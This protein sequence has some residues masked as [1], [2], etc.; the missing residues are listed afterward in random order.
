[1]K[2]VYLDNN[3]TTPLDERVLNA[4]LPFMKE[5]FGN[6]SSL[7]SFG[8]EAKAG[9][10]TAREKVAAL[11]G[12]E[13]SEI[14]FTSGGT[15]SD[16]I[17]LK[18]VAYQHQNKRHHL[19]ASAIEHHAV[20]ESVKFLAKNGFKADYLN[21]DREGLISAAE[22]KSKLTDDTSVVS[23]M[24]ANNEIGTIQNI[25]QLSEITHEK[26]ALFHTDAVQSA[27]KIE[28]DIKKLK[29]DLL[30]MSGHKIYGPKGVGVLYIAKGQRIVPLFHGGHHEKG[31]RAGT[32]NVAGIVG[33][34]AALELAEKMRPEEHTRLSNLA[35]FFIGQIQSKI[36]NVHFNG[37]RDNDKRIPSTVNL[38]F[39][40]VE[41]ESIILSLDMNGIGVASGSACTSGSLESSHVLMAMNIPPELAQGSIRFSL[42]RFTTKED[43]E[44]TISVLP[45]IIERLRAMSPL[46]AKK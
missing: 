34:A 35:D 16:N 5:K 13:P 41:G 36:S 45:E 33:F 46:Y 43:L 28:V 23:I 1:M 3:S 42:G 2:Q 4:R 25:T 32:E 44:Y 8:R 15:E 20:L 21:C 24:H 7:H 19:I 22:L 18:S 31:R 11:I 29:I 37:P 39:Q 26:G 10:E 9:I 38:S 14:Y 30:S 17:A 12:A 40:A 27:G 6:A